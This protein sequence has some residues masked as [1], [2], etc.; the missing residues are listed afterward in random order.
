MK[1]RKRWCHGV[2]VLLAAVCAAGCLSPEERVVLQ[3]S[4]YLAPSASALQG[5]QPRDVLAEAKDTV[6]D[7]PF[8]TRL[9]HEVA[10]QT[11]RSVVSIYVKTETPYEVTLLPFRI[12]GLKWRVRLPGIGLGSG[13]FVHESGYLLTNNH[14]VRDATQI[15]ALTY[16]EKHLAVS[17]VARDPSLDLALLKVDDTNQVFPV[18]PMG[19]SDA[20]GI[21]DMVIAVGNPLGLGHTVTSGIISQTGRDLS[22]VT[23][24]DVQRVRFLQTDAAVNPGSS[25]GPL[26]TLTGAWIGVNTAVAREAQGIGF[27]VPSAQVKEFIAEVLKRAPTAGS[28]P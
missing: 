5:A 25:G 19:N 3:G 8:R 27:A 17:V 10:E 13:F 20:V 18:L 1:S 4:F 12:L 16:D 2:F 15:R 28:G 7:V 11:K 26:I 6:V 23:Q 24:E 14:V 9:I 21:G 22:G